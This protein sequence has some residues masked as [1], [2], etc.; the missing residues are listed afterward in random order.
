MGYTIVTI[1]SDTQDLLAN[2]WCPKLSSERYRNHMHLQC[3]D[4][5]PYTLNK[6]EF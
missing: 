1:T 5:D 2:F 4:P 6:T 3:M